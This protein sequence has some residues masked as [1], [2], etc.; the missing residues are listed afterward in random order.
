MA[1]E[2]LRTFMEQTTR[3]MSESLARSGSY[4]H[5]SRLISRSILSF[6]FHG[7]SEKEG[8]SNLQHHHKLYSHLLTRIL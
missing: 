5:I 6:L 7:M 2:W 8:S 3:S 4:I 1:V